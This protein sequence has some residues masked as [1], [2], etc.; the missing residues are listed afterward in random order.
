MG[1]RKEKVPM[2]KILVSLP[3]SLA[4]KVREISEETGIPISSIIS[5]ALEGSLDKYEDIAL[6]IQKLKG[7]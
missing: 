3:K 2:E 6:E 1:K 5:Q 4:D 7:K